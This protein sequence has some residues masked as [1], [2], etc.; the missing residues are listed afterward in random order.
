[1]RRPP[2][3]LA[4]DDAQRRWDPAMTGFANETGATMPGRREHDAAVGH[5]FGLEVDGVRVT[6][7]TE[8]SGLA[9]ER[10]VI[11]VREGAA[12]GSSVTRLMPGRRKAG[13]VTLTRGLTSDR[14]FEHWVRDASLGA[15]AGAVSI[16]VFDHEGQ[17]VVTYALTRAWPRRLA[18][19]GLK[20]GANEPLTEQ[21]VLVYQ[22]FERT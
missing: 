18:I 21:L 11:E 2:G 3:I 16:V 22:S 14:T 19:G 13:E 10:D 7:L 9:M 15:G 20:A 6:M 1:M 17:A 4:V 5:S 12:D 8:V